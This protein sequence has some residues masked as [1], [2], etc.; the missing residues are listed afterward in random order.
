MV[1][2]EEKARQAQALFCDGFNCAQAVFAAY[3]EEVGMPADMAK[4][5]SAGLGGGMGRMR[6]VCGA[7]SALAMLA[8][9]RYGATDGQDIQAKK[10]TYEA[11]QRMAE[12]FREKNGSIICRELLGLNRAEGSAQPEARTQAYYKKRP[13]AQIVADAAR[14]AAEELF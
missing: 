1:D 12:R 3:A 4:R 13:C 8:G 7:M 11:V 2:C 5:V 10:Q 14:I 9:F 6:E